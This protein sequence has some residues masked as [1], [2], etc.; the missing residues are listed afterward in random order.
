MSNCLNNTAGCRMHKKE[1]KARVPK[2]FAEFAKRQE[3][4][5]MLILERLD[6]IENRL[7]H[8]E[9]R[10]DKHDQLFKDL[11]KANSLIDPTI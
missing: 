1:T 2:Y 11:I 6:R 9:T 4:F 10:L 8:V 7:T 3:A 5:N